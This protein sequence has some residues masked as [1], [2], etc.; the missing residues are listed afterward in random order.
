MFPFSLFSPYTNRK[1]KR[2]GKLGR[3]KKE[4]G[5]NDKRQL[6]SIRTCIING[7]IESP[8]VGQFVGQASSP[9]FTVSGMYG[10]LA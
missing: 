7:H 9:I 2:N 4:R 5:E 8:G 6:R 1:E 10:R 3:K